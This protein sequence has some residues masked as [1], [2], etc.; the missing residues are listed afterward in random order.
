M[1]HYVLGLCWDHRFGV[2]MSSVCGELLGS[3]ALHVEGIVR[4]HRTYLNPKSM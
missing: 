1:D 4:D 2:A 3:H